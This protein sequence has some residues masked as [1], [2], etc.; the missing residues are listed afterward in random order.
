MVQI[1]TLPPAGGLQPQNA[2]NYKGEKFLVAEAKL[3][4]LTAPS[5]VQ[6]YGPVKELAELCVWTGRSADASRHYATLWV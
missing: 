4:V 5:M 1:V 2:R 3:L 6:F